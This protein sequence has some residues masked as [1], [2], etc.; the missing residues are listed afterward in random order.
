MSKVVVERLPAGA[1]RAAAKELRSVL[2]GVPGKLEVV[3][4]LSDLLTESEILMASRRLAI[5]RR[6]LSGHSRLRIK[7]DLKVGFDTIA[8]VSSWLEGKFE[9]Y[10]RVI[11]P[12]VREQK[13]QRLQRC[14]P[15]RFSLLK[16]LLGGGGI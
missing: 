10:R 4:L 6:L 15:R 16:L 2:L 14:Y 12:L 7:R 11:P 3:D 5:A 1:W 8:R 13:F 9:D